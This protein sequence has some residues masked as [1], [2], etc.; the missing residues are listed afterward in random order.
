[1]QVFVTITAEP[2]ITAE[3]DCQMGIFAIWLRKTTVILN[4]VTHSGVTR[5]GLTLDFI[6]G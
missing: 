3:T 4:P 6:S 1:M 5:S 2:G